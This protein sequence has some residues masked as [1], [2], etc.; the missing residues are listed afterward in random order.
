MAS[1]S[2]QI[3]VTHLRAAPR[4]HSRDHRADHHRW[5]G[6][7]PED[8]RLPTTRRMDSPIVRAEI[9]GRLPR[10]WLDALGADPT[11]QL[12]TALR[13]R[14]CS[15]SGSRCASRSGRARTGE[16]CCST[17]T[18]PQPPPGQI[19]R[20]PRDRRTRAGPGFGGLLSESFELP[21]GHDRRHRKACR[22]GPF[23]LPSCADLAGRGMLRGRLERTAKGTQWAGRRRAISRCKA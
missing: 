18:T 1:T 22:P 6:V 7:D 12:P 23:L 9:T 14:H 16:R 5:N 19:F 15:S 2:D 4:S 10:G 3:Q 8:R 17:G 11:R 21:A 13:P 20:L